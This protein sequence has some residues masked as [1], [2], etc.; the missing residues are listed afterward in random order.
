MEHRA[1]AR[2]IESYELSADD[3]AQETADRRVL[4]FALERLAQTVPGGQVLEIGSG[5]GWDADVLEAAGLTV[6]RTD[7]TPAFIELQRARGKQV[8]QLDA[9][10]D[11]LG[12]PYDAVVALHVLQH[13]P[14]MT[15][16]GVL[17]KIFAALS[18]TGRFLVSIPRGQG[19][20]WQ[21][22]ESGTSY[23]WTL[24]TKDEFVALLRGAGFEPESIDQAVDDEERGWLCVM[25]R[26]A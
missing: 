19:E 25:A 17:T 1:D 2:T 3:Y 4:A 5:P 23:Y 11:D 20:G 10:R 26:R 16:P 22:D 14:S 24:H 7:I 8:D 18:P 21:F 12:G 13:V 6:R 9:I 15:L